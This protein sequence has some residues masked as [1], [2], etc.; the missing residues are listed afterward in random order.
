MY[1]AKIYPAAASP[2]LT[3]ILSFHSH[4]RPSYHST[5]PFTAHL[6]VASVQITPPLHSQGISTWLLLKSHHP[7][8][9]SASPRGF[10]SNHTPLHSQGIS[11]WLLLKSQRGEPVGAVQLS[12]AITRLGGREL[13]PC[14][15]APPPL[16]QA[17]GLLAL[18]P[19]AAAQHLMSGQA[20]WL[21]R[22]LGDGAVDA[23]FP[24]S[25]PGLPAVALPVG[26]S[27]FEGQWSRLTL[28]V[29]QLVM[30]SPGAAAEMRPRSVWAGVGKVEFFFARHL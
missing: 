4:T 12:L 29:D 6:H 1:T 30:P 3:P 20:P 16:M 9:H 25:P 8:I 23:P 13:D 24:G 15:G 11:T 7:S 26:P 5:P 19:V 2:L 21:M 14:H 28:H 10:C 27:G 18:L 17:P 22:Q